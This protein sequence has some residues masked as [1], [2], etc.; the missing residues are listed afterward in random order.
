MEPIRIRI[1]IIV[2]PNGKIEMD[3]TTPISTEYVP[4]VIELKTVLTCKRWSQEI[5]KK[6]QNSCNGCTIQCHMKGWYKG[7]T[8]EF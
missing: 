6:P 4:E 3:A 5:N 1:D 7:E 8:I 2:H